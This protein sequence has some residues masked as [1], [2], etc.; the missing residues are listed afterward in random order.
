MQIVAALPPSQPTPVIRAESTKTGVTFVWSAPDNGGSPI[1]HYIVQS[2]QGSGSNF[3]QIAVTGASTTS[4]QATGLVTSQVYDFRVIAVNDVG[5]SVASEPSSLIIATIPSASGQPVKI[6]NTMSSVTI[7]WTEPVDDG[8]TPI[9]DYHVQ[10]DSGSGF[11]TIGNTGSGAVLQF[12]ES[13]LTPG[14][15]YYFLVIAENIVGMGPDSPATKIIAGLE[16]Q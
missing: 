2:N 1:T 14:Q 12:T 13:G 6:S 7:E 16:P 5:Q 4:Y 15:D 10:M 9:T 3:Y 8:A 11:I